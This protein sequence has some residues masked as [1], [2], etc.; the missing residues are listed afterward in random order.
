MV[1]GSAFG[2]CRMVPWC[3]QCLWCLVVS[4]VS[5]SWFLG[6]YS[7]HGVYGVWLCLLCLSHG[8]LV[9]TVPVASMVS[10]SAFGVGLMVPWCIQ[11]HGAYGVW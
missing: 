7:A 4:S 6:V 8:S 11:C 5:V 1:S 10:G 2:V 9:S 3:L